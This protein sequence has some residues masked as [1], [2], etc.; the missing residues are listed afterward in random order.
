[1]STVTAL[2]LVVAFQQSADRS[3]VSLILW[4]VIAASLPMPLVLV[5]TLLRT[6]A[7]DEAATR[8]LAIRIIIVAYVPLQCALSLL[9]FGR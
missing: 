6:S 7:H 1:M 2:A 9:M 8:T 4:L 5:R 3:L